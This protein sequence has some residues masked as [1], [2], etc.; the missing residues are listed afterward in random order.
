MLDAAALTSMGIGHS[1]LACPRAPY[2]AYDS[3]FGSHNGQ[4]VCKTALS[5]SGPQRCNSLH[6]TARYV[7]RRLVQHRPDK[8]FLKERD[9]LA[10]S[11]IDSYMRNT[12]DVLRMIEVSRWWILV[13]HSTVADQ[14]LASELRV[15]SGPTT[16]S[17]VSH[18]SIK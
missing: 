6:D 7:V 12:S 2:P 17:N 3:T 8:A 11:V 4:Q 5:A 10:D 14:R 16:W 1:I 18:G 15:Q 9:D 13:E